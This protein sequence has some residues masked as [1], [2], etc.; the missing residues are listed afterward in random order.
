[1]L[2]FPPIFSCNVHI[3][4]SFHCRANDYYQAGKNINAYLHDVLSC[5][6]EY[7]YHPCKRHMSIIKNVTE[8]SHILFVYLMYIYL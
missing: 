2:V 3:E 7:S 1:M 5:V 4:L 8:G 6:I